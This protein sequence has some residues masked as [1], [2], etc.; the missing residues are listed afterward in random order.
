MDCVLP[1]YNHPNVYDLGFVSG[2]LP[3]WINFWLLTWAASAVASSAPN[4]ILWIIR[5]RTNRAMITPNVMTIQEY[6]DTS[7][8]PLRVD[9]A[10]VR[11]PESL[12]AIYICHLPRDAQS[13]MLRR[14]G[15]VE[16]QQ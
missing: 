12:I 9:L 16:T 2:R 3:R 6:K 5:P 11:A 10:F 8:N 15:E 14:S 1:A 4:L 7:T 13:W